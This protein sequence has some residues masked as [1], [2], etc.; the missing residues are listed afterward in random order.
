MAML[1]TSVMREAISDSVKVSKRKGSHAVPSAVK[2]SALSLAAS[3]R[4]SKGVNEVHL[5]GCV[6]SLPTAKIQPSGDEVVEFR[7]VIDRMQRRGGEKS[8]RREVDSLEIAAWNP[9]ERRAALKLQPGD[10]VRI[11]GSVHRRFWSSPKGI[12]SRWQ[13]EVSVL[14]RL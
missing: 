3:K 5:Q 14:R 4:V 10:W 7:I 6:S 13:I 12:A 1:D 2:P 8:L 11:E 9:R